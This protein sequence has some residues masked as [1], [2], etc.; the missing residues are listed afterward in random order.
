MRKQREELAREKEREYWDPLRKVRRTM[1]TAFAGARCHVGE[2]RRLIL[3]Q[4][5]CA[6][7]TR[8]HTTS[9]SRGQFLKLHERDEYCWRCLKLNCFLNCFLLSTKKASRNIYSRERQSNEIERERATKK[10]ETEQRKFQ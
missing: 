1:C 8:M 6:W 9:M 2:L 7:F 3:A 5:D 10:R 4:L